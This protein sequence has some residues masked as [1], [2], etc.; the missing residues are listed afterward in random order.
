[1]LQARG[2]PAPPPRGGRRTTALAVDPQ[3][4]RRA[5]STGRA[6]R[7]RRPV[8]DQLDVGHHRPAQVRGAQPEPVDVLPPA[9]GRRRRH[10]RRRRV[11]QRDPRAVRLRPLDRARHA[12]GAR[13]ADRRARA[14]RRRRRDPRHRTRAGHRA[15]LRE[16]AVPHDAELADRR[17]ARPVVAA[18]HV[19]RRRGGARTSAPRASRTSPARA[20]CSSTAPTRPARSAAPRCATTASTGCRPR[21]G[22]SPRCTCACSTTTATTSPT[23]GTPGN[24]VCKG[25]ATCLGYLDDDPR[26]RGAVHARRLDAHR[27]PVRRSTPTATSA[28]SGARPT[29][30]S[31]AARTSAPPRSKAEV[32]EHPAIAVAAAVAMPDEVFGERVCL[33][34]E[35]EPGTDARPRRRSSRSSASA[36]CRREWFPERLVVVDA[37]PRAS[38]GKVAKG[39]LRA[40]IR[41][42]LAHEP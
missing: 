30:S 36:A 41:R 4:R 3:R 24:P 33:Y 9:R 29:S 20:C 40:D 8:P 17:A 13:R 19:H 6:V 42:R 1:M 7:T 11:P 21:A 16:H 31:A 12:R 38:G 37:L 18:V 39:E 22:S 10:D 35:L 5:T 15:R 26:Q 25:P 32:A 2:L 28:S 27:R 14:L 34:V 23:P